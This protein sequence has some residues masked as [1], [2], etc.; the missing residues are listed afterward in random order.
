M[1]WLFA[2]DDGRRGEDDGP[3]PEDNGHRPLGIWLFE[4]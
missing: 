3:C 1:G 4:L 2:N